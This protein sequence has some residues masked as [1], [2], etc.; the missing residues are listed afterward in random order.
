MATIR[1]SRSEADTR[2]PVSTGRVSSREAEVATLSA[3][4]TNASTGSETAPSACGSGNG[5]KSSD[6]SVRMWNVAFPETSSTSCSEARSSSETLSSRQQS[7][8]VEQ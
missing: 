1:S 5:G 6:L 7:D 4:E 8:D 2:I 3:V